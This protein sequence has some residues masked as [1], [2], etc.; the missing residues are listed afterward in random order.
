MNILN[1]LTIKH[2][3]MNK[4]RTVV[5]IIGILLSTALMV[6]IGLLFSSV[7]DYMMKETRNN[8]GNYHVS[9]E[10]ITAKDLDVVKHNIN[11]A[12]LYYEQS[13]GYSKLLKSENQY[14]PY[15]HLMAISDSYFKELKLKEG[16]LPSQTDEI[17]ISNHLAS[18]GGVFYQIGDSLTVAYGKRVFPDDEVESNNGFMEGE[19]L[20]IQET[21]TYKIVGIVER[22]VYEP[23]DDPGYRVYVKET[24]STTASYTGYLTYKNPKDVYT[25]TEQI[26]TSIGKMN[27]EGTF[28][29]QYN[30]GLL[31]LYGQSAYGNLISG[32]GSI[33]IIML[34]LVSV[35]CIIVIYN[36][37]AISV[38]ERKKQFGLFSSIGTTR[39]QLQK[40]V[41]FEAILVGTIGILLGVL[42]GI[43]GI[44]VVLEIVNR[45]LS[46]IFTLKLSLS[47]YPL[48][49]AIPIIFMIVVIFI[50][51]FLPARRAS[52]ITPIEAIRQ[53]DDIK[54]V[55]KKVKTYRWVKKLFG[56]EGE[57]ALKNMKRNKKKYRITIISLFISIVLFISFSGLLQLGITTSND[58]QILP[59]FD[60]QVSLYNQKEKDPHETQ[61][62]IQDIVKKDDV[63]EYTVLQAQMETGQLLERNLYTNAYLNYRKEPSNSYYLIGMD[64]EKLA[65][66]REKIG[67]SDDLPI[68]INRSKGVSYK[69]GSRVTYDVEIFKNPQA[70][71]IN[72]CRY[73]KEQEEICD[74]KLGK[75]HSTTDIPFGMIAYVADLPSVIV[76][77]YEKLDEFAQRLYGVERSRNSY[78]IF[79]T[80]ANET[81]FDK[82][83]VEY[84]DHQ[85]TDYFSYMNIKDQLQ[86]Q[87]NMILVIQILLYGFISLVTL[88]GITSVFNTINTSIALRRKEFAMLRSM[89]LTPGGFNKMIFFESLFFGLKSLL[90]A[91][92][93]SVVVIFLFHLSFGQI[94]SITHFLLP[95]SSII[96]SIV[97]VFLIVLLTMMYATHK[98]KKENILDAIRE[99]NI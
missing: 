37:F 64:P 98:M 17:V 20:E 71:S 3:K 33:M 6:G 15:L 31:A 43:F 24:P 78:N 12:D 58:F 1:R 38:M 44:W 27:Q 26:A 22:S 89:G 88:I 48:F 72:F 56:M 30:D 54:I 61:R 40:T 83:M 45:L 96:I 8:N 82:R 21:K 93:V 77:S 14:K 73:D 16:R 41:F 92:P 55:G 67:V 25:K 13:L 11:V 57:I 75:M 87:R 69:D 36:S 2:L 51:A 19:K 84:Q 70:L 94:T 5:S 95:W 32:F 85:P 76:M 79:V 63:K 65:A 80:M 9:I 49:V 39:K 66:W 7:R 68:L 74:V 97:G 18:D 62:V 53:N 81:S 99:E 29:I 34:S 4:K 59:D 60:S 35:G 47:I 10:D 28:D 42:S 86:I 91:L 46:S 90:Y 50:S 52:K 23:Y